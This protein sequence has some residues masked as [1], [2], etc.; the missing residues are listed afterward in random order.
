MDEQQTENQ[1]VK[2][3]EVKPIEAAPQKNGRNKVLISLTLFLLVATLVWFLVWFLYFRFHE[4]TDDAYANGSM[5]NLNSAIP[6]SVI[7]FYADDTDLVTQGQLIVQLDPTRY[8][9]AYDEALASL[10]ATVL[11]VRRLYDKVQSNKAAVETKEAVLFTAN[12]DYQ[13]RTR[14]VGSKAISNEEFVHSKDALVMA[15]TDL[16]Q[17]QAELQVSLDATGNSPM[18]N[19][20]LIEKEKANVRIAYYNLKHTAIYAPASGYVAQRFVDVGEWVTPSTAMMAIIPMDYVWVDANYKE[21]QL[22][23]MRIGQKVIV[24]FD[25]YGSD[26]K[27]HGKV[28]GIAFGSGS[29]FS[30]IPP[31]NATGNWIKIVQRL[32]VRISLDPEMVKK[33]PIRLGI[34]AEVHVDVTDQDLP[35]IAETPATKLIAATDV[36][37][38]HLEEVEKVINA[39][40]EANLKP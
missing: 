5:I 29:V 21:T 18:I 13:N 27:Y 30:L 40:V 8:Q 9:V 26:V 12:Y 38:I 2:P 37:D 24:T 32:P 33:Y 23:K 36:F 7:A 11:D 6:G 10:A 15:Q 34:S 20:P 14:L 1:E 31:Q 25:L 28:L 4:Y 16:A 35:R 19:H 3:V 39:V 22:T 17:A